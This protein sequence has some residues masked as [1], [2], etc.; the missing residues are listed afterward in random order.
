MSLE[1]T[2]GCPVWNHRKPFAV[3]CSAGYISL[4]LFA[5]AGVHEV[6][7][8]PCQKKFLGGKMWHWRFCGPDGAKFSGFFG[9]V[10]GMMSRR[11]N[12]CGFASKRESSFKMQRLKKFR[13]FA[14]RESIKGSPLRSMLLNM[15]SL[16]MCFRRPSPVPKGDF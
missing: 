4:I 14:T 11:K 2:H 15:P 12:W 6:Y 7:L 10:R 1:N 8:Q 3:M 16:G 5:F 13:T 9:R